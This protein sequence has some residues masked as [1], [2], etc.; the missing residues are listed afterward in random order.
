[1]IRQQ[2]NPANIIFHYFRTPQDKKKTSQGERKNFYPYS[3]FKNAG[4]PYFTQTAQTHNTC[5]A[6]SDSPYPHDTSQTYWYEAQ[7]LVVHAT[8]TKVHTDVVLAEVCNHQGCKLLPLSTVNGK[9]CVY[10]RRARTNL[11]NSQFLQKSGMS[12]S[13][14][15]TTAQFWLSSV[16]S[17]SPNLDL[18]T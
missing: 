9:T 6:Q 10:T 18:V 15:K 16:P 5:D 3:P 8:D 4:Q 12:P 2:H 1:M 11:T 14:G 13:I 17:F 7:L